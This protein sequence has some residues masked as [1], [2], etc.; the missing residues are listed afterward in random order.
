MLDFLS[1]F[2]DFAIAFFQFKI[3]E[4]Y[5]AHSGVSPKLL[6]FLLIGLAFQYLVLLEE[7]WRSQWWWRKHGDSELSKANAA[8]E[9]LLHGTPL[10]DFIRTLGYTTIFHFVLRLYSSSA[11]LDIRGYAATLNALLA[12]SAFESL[13]FSF[14]LGFQGLAYFISGMADTVRREY[15]PASGGFLRSVSLAGLIFVGLPA[16]LIYVYLLWAISKF[17]SMSF[18]SILPPL[19][20]VLLLFVAP[21]LLL[22]RKFFRSLGEAETQ[23]GPEPQRAFRGWA[24]PGPGPRKGAIHPSDP[25]PD[26]PASESPE[27]DKPKRPSGWL[28]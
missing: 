6:G 16:F 1:E 18:T 10:R 26:T 12:Y 21:T 19:A 7:R 24:E 13:I 20:I 15:K 4:S 9:D 22:W 17:H 25:G 27:P 8:V 11:D 14:L 5:L 28:S 23:S 3:A 2:F